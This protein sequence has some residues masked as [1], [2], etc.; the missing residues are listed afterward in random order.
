MPTLKNK[1][2]FITGASRGIGLAIALRA[3]RDGANIAIAA[4]TDRPHPKLEGT[5][6]TAAE[7]IEKAGGK[8]LPLVVDIRDDEAVEL[9]VTTAANHFGGIDICVNN[10]SAIALTDTPSTPMKRFDLMHGVNARGTFLTSKTCLPH[11]MRAENPH[12]LMISPPL[13]MSPHWFGPH[14]AYSMA[15][16]GMSLCVL[17]MAA[18]FRERGIAVNALWPR[19]TIA[20]AA[21]RN[22][23][24]GEAIERASR[25][26]E[27]MAD[28]AHIILT[29]PSP[30][31]TGRFCIDDTLL[32][33]HGTTDFDHYRVDASVD[34]QPDFFV[35]QDS[36]P[37]ASLRAVK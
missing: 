27:I 25:Q 10:A 28:A 13:D 19:T 33:E 1:T 16:Y 29:R 20:T 8:A 30:E 6:H 15:K 23:L 34:L 22:L 26:P 9:A 24:G 11:L 18:E 32:A 36:H 21:I 2:L 7:A 12:I 3:A 4:K 17:G 35:P 31:F 14:V 37:P 5:I